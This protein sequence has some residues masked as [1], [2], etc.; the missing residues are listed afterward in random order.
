MWTS[1]E[2]LCEMGCEESN[3]DIN[4]DPVS[5]FG[6]TPPALQNIRHSQHHNTLDVEQDEFPYPGNDINSS[7]FGATNNTFGNDGS[8]MS[9]EINLSSTNRNQE[10][11]N[12]HHLTPPPSAPIDLSYNTPIHP[13]AKRTHSQKKLHYTSRKYSLPAASTLF[14]DRSDVDASHVDT[15]DISAIPNIRSG[16]P[17]TNNPK[18]RSVMFDTPNL[19]PIQLHA[20]NTSVYHPDNLDGPHTISRHAN[21]NGESTRARLFNNDTSTIME[22]HSPRQSIGNANHSAIAN[23]A[24]MAPPSASFHSTNTTNPL[25]LTQARK[26][27]A[28]LY[29]EP[30][31]E[32]FTPNRNNRW[33]LSS[34]YHVPI[35]DNQSHTNMNLNLSQSRLSFSDES[36]TTDIASTKKLDLSLNQTND[37]PPSF[38]ISRNKRAPIHTNLSETQSKTSGGVLGGLGGSTTK[39]IPDRNSEKNERIFEPMKETKDVKDVVTFD[40]FDV[41]DDCIQQILSLLC[42][43]GA[44]F[45][46][47]CQVSL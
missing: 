24:S 44:S 2:S 3:S 37:D 15:N 29:Y 19:T 12:M 10:G 20:T 42:T 46:L 36:E 40:N 6:V 5:I 30:S 7:V 38:S 31:P 23:I 43:L 47:L 25:V 32:Q 33:S 8:L 34:Q 35:K 45:R 4:I 21:Q 9:P 39:T 14:G 13:S 17:N 1:Y 16:G 22:H 27:V 11:H 26:V 18:R 28:R 41:D